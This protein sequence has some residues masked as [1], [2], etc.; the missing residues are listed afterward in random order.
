MSAEGKEGTPWRLRREFGMFVVF[1]VVNLILTYAI[2][3][4]LR[5]FLSYP[6][7]YT[8]SYVCG[9]L[10]SYVLNARFVFKAKLRVS[11]ALQYP[12]VYV[13][14][15]L[16]GIAILF[17]LVEVAHVRSSLAPLAIPV[18]TVPATYVL[19]R[20]LIKGRSSASAG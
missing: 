2:Y 8:G 10:I 18:V 14:Q 7:A 4:T 9:I 11:K 16:L 12:I 15:Y 17:L 13:V 1:G 20:Y 6:A 19:S 5:L 3:L